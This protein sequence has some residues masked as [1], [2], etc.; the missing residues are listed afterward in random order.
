MG[1]GVLTLSP[2]W[3]LQ[4]F[5]NYSSGCLTLVLVPMEFPAHRFLLSQ[6]VILCIGPFVSVIFGSVVCPMTS[7]L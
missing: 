4:R 7:L 2:H 6:V 5:I 1:P 3:S